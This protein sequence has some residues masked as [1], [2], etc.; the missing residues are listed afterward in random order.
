MWHTDDILDPT[1][2]NI[3]VIRTIRETKTLHCKTMIRVKTNGN[4]FK[5][6]CV[7]IR[8]HYTKEF[9]PRDSGTYIE[10]QAKTCEAV[11]S[12]EDNGAVL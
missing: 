2:K 12:S 4:A 3:D 8:F 5:H 9:I 11:Q 10:S 6:T 7:D 1:C